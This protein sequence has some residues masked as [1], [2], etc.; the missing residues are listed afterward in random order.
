MPQFHPT[1]NTWVI[2]YVIIV[3]VI[4]IYY[5]I[6]SRSRL[7]PDELEDI[8]DIV[9]NFHE[10]PNF[11][12]FLFIYND[13]DRIIKQNGKPVKFWLWGVHMS[14]PDYYNEAREKVLESYIRDIERGLRR[15]K[16]RPNAELIDCVWAIYFATGDKQYADIIKEIALNCPD[17]TVA[18]AANWS[19][20]SIMGASP[21]AD[22]PNIT[23]QTVE[24]A[25]P[26]PVA[27]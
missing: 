3:L 16:N 14:H 11:E 22:V 7:T 6:E 18:G 23:N 15:V 12:D 25:E 13:R 27:Q 24:Q 1:I 19:Y 9:M 17:L 4:W 5:W 2:A 20:T 26:Q 21:Y 8:E 10:D